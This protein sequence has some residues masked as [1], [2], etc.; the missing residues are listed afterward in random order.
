AEDL[1][2]YMIAEVSKLGTSYQQFAERLAQLPR[3]NNEESEA[4][5]AADVGYAQPRRSFVIAAHDLWPNSFAETVCLAIEAVISHSVDER[6]DPAAQL[7]KAIQT[8]FERPPRRERT[9]LSLEQDFRDL[10]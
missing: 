5:S 6:A 2:R 9:H 3:E 10:V 7:A 8:G 4:E 1:I